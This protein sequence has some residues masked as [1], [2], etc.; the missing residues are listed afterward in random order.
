MKIVE[1]GRMAAFGSGE[2]GISHGA[3]EAEQ[4]FDP[5]RA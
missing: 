4:L 3:F 1:F 2:V 5:E